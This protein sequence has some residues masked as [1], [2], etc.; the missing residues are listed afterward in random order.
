[1]T[2]KKILIRIGSLRHGGAE[3]VLIT[4]LKNLPADKYEVDLLLNLYS[5]KYIPEIPDWVNVMYLNRGE[6]ITTNRPKDIPK[7]AY[8]VVYQQLLKKYPKILYKRKLK[9][10]KYDIEFAA[11]HGFMDEILNSPLKSSKKLMWIHNDLTK[12]EGYTT[13]KIK[14][15]FRYDKI[16]V[17]SEHIQKTFEKLA[18]NEAEKSKIVRIYNP[19]DTEEILTKSE[20]ALDSD[21][22]D[23]EIPSFVSVGT[24]F[25]Q[26]GFDRLLKVHKQLL[27][28][29]FLHK[30]IIIGDGYDFENIKNL[31]SELKLDKTAS[32]IGFTDN[33]YPYFKKADFF[34]LS[35]RYEGFPTVLFEAMTLT[36]NIIATDVS[37][38]KEMLK[39]GELGL[40]VEN[41]EK[42]IYTG[43]KQALTDA[44]SFEL[45]QQ[46]LNSY[47]MPFNLKNSV[48]SITDI[49]DNL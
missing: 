26:K 47:E 31:K 20:K 10:K 29:G 4:F 48:K 2:K 35:S 42:G 15:F 36:K 28:E 49:I 27:D 37:G 6:M 40:I 17:I 12:V 32:M 38:V 16:M 46:K 39:N 33:P 19:L 1:M 22:F 43:M 8:R 13:E 44:K 5:G 11:I 18:N 3:K 7:K 23:D 30:V 25:P 45:Y 41:S 21:L 24:V 14:R 9:N 34:V